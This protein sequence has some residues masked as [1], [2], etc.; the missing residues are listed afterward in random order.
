MAVGRVELFQQQQRVHPHVALGVVLG[1]LLH[2]LHGGHFGQEVV[3]QAG[4]IQQL[5]AA[6]RAAFGQDADQLV[7]NALGG[8]AAG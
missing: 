2:A 4:R 6:P 5:E 1:R 7:A 3:Q 8:D